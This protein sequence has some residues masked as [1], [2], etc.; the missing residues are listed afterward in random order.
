[1]INIIFIIVLLVFGIL[2]GLIG[3]WGYAKYQLTSL[4]QRVK[5]L[6]ATAESEVEVVKKNMII[7]TRE[8]IQKEKREQDIEIRNRFRDLTQTETRLQKKEDLIDQKLE[9]L[10][11]NK[12]DIIRKEKDLEKK[13]EKVSQADFELNAKLENVARLTIEDAQKQLFEQAEAG[14]KK[15]IADVVYRIEQES[16]QD[17][18]RKAKETM[19]R[20]AQRMVSEITAEMT[21]STVALPSE[22]MKG[23]IIGK[24]GRNIRAIETLTG[25]DIIVDDTPD[26]V[27]V[28]CFNP[29]RRAIAIETLSNLV[30]DGRIHP[31]RIE[32]EVER[33]TKNL[34]QTVY[35][36]GEKLFMSVGLQG[37]MHVDVLRVLGKLK[38]RTS[39]GQNIYYHSQEVA[40]LAGVMAKELGAD[41]TIAKRGALF[42]DI[43]KAIDSDNDFTHVELGVE[44][45]KRVK[46]SDEVI[47]CIAAHHGDVPH[48]CL[49]SI[50]VQIADAM[51]AAR[52]GA[53][54]DTLD[55]Y[56]ERL[57]KLEEIANSFAG[58]DHAYAVHAGRELRIVVKND[59]MSDADVQQTA[60]EI[61]LEIEKNMKYPGRIKVT[62]IRE[63]RVVEYAR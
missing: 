55:N 35:E 51:S 2:L 30:K 8:M 50:I 48:S 10:D 36:A 53:R 13:E 14:A 24:E 38:F 45:A 52:P 33:V 43:G 5:R 56:I 41:T 11:K 9:T 31:S 29:I 42:H 44:L 21:I 54:R 63:T 34:N 6:Q 58:I 59:E 15:E 28:S 61:C 46:E 1:M 26:V 23:R 60:R 17:A 37:T 18:D 49:E 20:A 22:D 27:I 57:G 25:A 32:E 7:E 47:N 16:I 40:H 4:E 3:R 62:A 39:Y 12:A 19:L